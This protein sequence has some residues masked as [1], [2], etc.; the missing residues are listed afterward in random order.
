MPFVTR[1]LV[2]SRLPSTSLTE[3]PAIDSAVSS[4]TVC[5]PGTV[6]TGPSFTELTVIA[7]VSES[8]RA[9]AGRDRQ[10]VGAVE[11]GV[12]LVGRARRARR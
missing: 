12:A 7:T 6:F 5:A 8:V 10:R 3:T 4:L 11:V 9:V 1:Q 2:V